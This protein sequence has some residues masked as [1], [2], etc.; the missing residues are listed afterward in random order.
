MAGNNIQKPK[1]TP[2]KPQQVDDFDDVDVENTSDETPSNV[3]P[4][5]VPTKAKG[6][7]TKAAA[8]VKT[9]LKVVATEKGFYN[10]RR[11]NIGDKFTIRSEQDF[12][13]NWMKYI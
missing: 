12:S 10:N 1:L 11:L 5:T 13:E 3:G 9:G 4:A 6:P 7:I 8:A 2:P